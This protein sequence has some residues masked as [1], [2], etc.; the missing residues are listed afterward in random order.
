MTKMAESTIQKNSLRLI[1][2]CVNL[3]DAMFQGIYN[4]KQKH[5]PD[6]DLVMERAA[7]VGVSEVI[8]VSGS[9]EDSR[10]SVAAAKET[11][12]VFASVGVHPTR[13]NEFEES[14]DAEAHLE[15]LRALVVE[16]GDRIVAIGEIGLDYDREQFCGRD[17]QVSVFVLLYN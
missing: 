12:N 13:C 3:Q 15:A 1:D 10:Q 2:T 14:G 11:K 17:V 6:W 9:L 5:E 7:A 8:A 16:A 4:E